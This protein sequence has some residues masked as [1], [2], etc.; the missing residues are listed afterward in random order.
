LQGINV[1]VEP[2]NIVK[3]IPQEIEYIRVYTQYRKPETAAEEKQT[4]GNEK[5]RSMRL[6]QGFDFI[7]RRERLQNPN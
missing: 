7:L 2:A 5:P 6:E 1:C 3:D 4:L